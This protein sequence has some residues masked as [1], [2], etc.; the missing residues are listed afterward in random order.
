[1]LMAEGGLMALCLVQQRKVPLR[2]C[3]FGRY[4]VF[5]ISVGE[6]PIS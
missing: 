2:L 6:A 5:F 3:N 4:G 1:M